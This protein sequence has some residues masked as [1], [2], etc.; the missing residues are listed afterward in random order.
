[1]FFNYLKGG[2]KVCKA[3]VVFT[4]VNI[5]VENQS[6][7]SIEIIGTSTIPAYSDGTPTAK[8]KRVFHMAE[9]IW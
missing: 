4:C 6:L 8:S 7:D 2:Q 5:K 9:R 3:G 1:M